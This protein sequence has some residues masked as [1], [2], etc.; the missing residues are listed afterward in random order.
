MLHDTHAHLT[1]PLIAADAEAM[2]ERAAAAGVTRVIANGL[3]YDDN[4]AVQRLAGAHPTI[5]RPAYGLYP[6]DAVLDEMTA[7]GVEYP[8]DPGEIRAEETLSWIADHADEA[9]AIGEVGLDGKWVPE[10]F[11]ELQEQRFR[12]LVELAVRVDKPLIIHSRKREARCFEIC[13]EMGVERVQFHAYSSKLKL[14]RRIAEAGYYLSVP[15]NAPRADQYG[16][17]LRSLPR[18]RL[19][20]ETDAPYM[21]PDRERL[22]KNEPAAV[23]ETAAYASELW[24]LSAEQT[25]QRFADNYRALF[26]DEPA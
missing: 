1:H 14:A 15:A 16:Q 8:R 7:A 19:L 10:P 25:A 26:R 24:E 17:L 13:Q 4:L 6:V 20:L 12:Q 23:A 3:N 9:I 21:S 22:P 2:L 18:E 5:V 11:W